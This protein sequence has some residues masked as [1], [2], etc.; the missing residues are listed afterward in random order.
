MT[1]WASCCAF[2]HIEVE[3]DYIRIISA[4]KATPQE[5][6]TPMIPKHLKTRL[7]K[8]RPM[9]SITLRIPT[10]VVDSLRNGLPRTKGFSGY[11]ALLKAYISEGLRRD[12]AVHLFGGP[13]A[14]L[15]GS[16][17]ETWGLGQAH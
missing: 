15:G 1:R 5:R 8:A 10:D 6:H 13:A 16:A 14:R 11:Q 17:A 9:T 12:E 4:R 2:V 7:D 3:E